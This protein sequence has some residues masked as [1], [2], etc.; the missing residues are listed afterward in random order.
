MRANGYI[1]PSRRGLNILFLLLSIHDGFCLWPTKTTDYSVSRAHGKTDKGTLS[2]KCPMLVGRKACSSVCTYRLDRHE[3]CYWDKAAY[4]DFYAEQLTELLT[5]YGPLVEVWFD[6]AGSQGREYDWQRIIG[7][8]TQYQP[9]AMIFNTGQ[10]T[11]RWV[12]NED[13]ASPIPVLEHGG[14]GNT[15]ICA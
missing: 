15:G 6:G 11:I 2:V 14:Y 12:G 9:E 5:Q 4:D 3:R 10:P 1:R 7:L 8:V 13:E